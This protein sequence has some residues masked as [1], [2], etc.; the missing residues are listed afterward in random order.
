MLP[1]VA[2]TNT[3]SFQ[4]PPVN[5]TIPDTN[6]ARVPYTDV[7][8]SVSGAQI[9][10][11]TQ[12]NNTVIAR[13]PE[14]TATQSAAASESGGSNFLAQQQSSINSSLSSGVQATFVAQLAAQDVSDETRGVLV[15][16]EKL[17]ANANIKYKPSNAAKPQEGPSSVFGRLL[18]SEASNVPNNEAPTPVSEAVVAA[19]S[20]Q[21][22][23]EAIEAAPVTNR[24]AKS[25]PSSTSAENESP[26]TTAPAANTSDAI[27]PR[28][29]SAYVSTAG[30]VNSFKPTDTGEGISAASELA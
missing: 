1:I 29:I 8:P 6:V 19:N 23:A 30:R 5:T 15:Q 13:A 2:S 26:D 9:N 24:P 22:S 4:T 21:V 10:N 3:V 20:N 25:A 12:G 16:Y 7:A 27:N 17:V 11:N 28:A 14:Q 18:Q